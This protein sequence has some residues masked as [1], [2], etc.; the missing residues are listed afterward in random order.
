MPHPR[1]KF[2][3][4]EIRGGV[5]RRSGD[6]EPNVHAEHGY[7]IRLDD[8]PREPASLSMAVWVHVVLTEAERRQWADTLLEGL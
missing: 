2:V 5:L 8:Q 4:Q 6:P 7:S 1:V 3:S